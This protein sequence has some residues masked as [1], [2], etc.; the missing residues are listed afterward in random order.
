MR[1]RLVATSI[2]V[3]LAV[4]IALFISGFW[5]I[6]RL[7][8]ERLHVDI[9]RVDPLPEAPAGG[10][11][12]AAAPKLVPKKAKVL[13]KRIVQP[14]VKPPDAAEVV[15]TTETGSGSDGSGG[16]SGAGSGSG[17]GSGFE[18]VTGAGLG[19]CARTGE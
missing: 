19:D 17:S 8:A 9:M 14:E 15:S 7:E 6:S 13:T 3:H 18:L 5:H 11:T 16:G 1:T 10:P 2:V 4:V 12:A